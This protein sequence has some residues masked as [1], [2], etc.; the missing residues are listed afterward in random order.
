[1]LLTQVGND[2][3]SA[4]GR[5]NLGSIYTSLG[6]IAAAAGCYA[7]AEGAIWSFRDEAGLAWAL[8][9][10]PGPA[11]PSAPAPPGPLCG[12]AA[13]R[14]PS[15]TRRGSSRRL[16]ASLVRWRSAGRRSGG[17]VQ[18]CAPPTPALSTLSE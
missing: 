3:V 7:R 11:I 4:R 17:R 5:L 2:L 13:P 18:R 9:G 14:A 12:T 10:I 15:P 8:P 16:L 1:E 6:D